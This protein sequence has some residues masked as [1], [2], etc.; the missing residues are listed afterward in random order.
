M[1]QRTDFEEFDRYLSGEASAE[2]RARLDA[3]AATD[4]RFRELLSAA[5][6]EPIAWDTNRAWTELRGRMLRQPRTRAAWRAPGFALAAMLVIALGVLVVQ[7]RR[8]SLRSTTQVAQLE[9]TTSVGERKTVTLT[10][11]SA[12]ELAPASRLRVASDFRRADR[13]VTLEG[14]AFFQ[15]TRDSTR[16]FIVR[17]AVAETRVLGTSFDVSAYGGSSVQVAVTSGRVRVQAV[18][19]RD[20]AVLSAG[21][22]A[23]VQ[24]SGDVEVRAVDVADLTGWREGRLV[25]RDLSFAEAGAVLERWYGIDVVIADSTL[26]NTH[27]TAFF[28]QQPLEDVLQALAETVGARYQRAA[29]RVT[30]YPKR[31]G[32]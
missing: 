9:Y 6:G 15:V 13:T 20:S 29:T 21:Q 4:P 7:Q 30:F 8:E 31:A 27:V 32:S 18:Q 16:P 3:R 24:Q 14:E 23:E 22:V 2:E 19:A 11:G 17:S 1:D 12:V 5:R 26:A 25:F 28:Q 10:D